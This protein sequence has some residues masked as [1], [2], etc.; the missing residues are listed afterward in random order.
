MQAAQEP[1]DKLDFAPGS[2]IQM[3]LYDT[4]SFPKYL[5]GYFGLGR[6]DDKY[7]CGDERDLERLFDNSIINISYFA[8]L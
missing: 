5:L 4:T 8:R 3:L 1:Q 6:I 2:N 7:N